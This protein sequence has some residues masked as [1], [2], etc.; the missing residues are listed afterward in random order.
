MYV[1]LHCH[2]TA[3][4]GSLPPAEV[5]RIA[6]GAGV[7][8][9]SLTDHDTVAGNA[10][11]AEE[12]KK[13]GID[14]VTGIEI[15]CE[16][17]SPGTMH[18][19]GYGVDPTSSVLAELSGT[20]IENR[21]NRNPRIIRRLNELNVAVTMEEWEDAAG[22]DVIGRPHLAQILVRKGYANSVKQV[23]DKYLGQGGQAYFDK[24]KLPRKRALE[25]IFASGGIAVLAHPYQLRCTNDAELETIVKDLADLG[26]AG[27]EVMH[28]DHDAAAV[29]K[30]SQLADR[31]GLIRTGGSDFHGTSK[32]SISLGW[33][34]GSRIPR[35]F[36]DD[37]LNAH[38]HHHV[39]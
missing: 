16:F 19:L 18:I 27:I 28:S 4:D 26:L 25:M 39:A 37:L 24:E 1:D 35:A 30:Y 20:L 21:N 22:G 33:C 12:A 29:R 2:S 34:N 7:C 32:K 3:S 23:F 11:A 9:M 31:F 5:V 14:F 17:R 8:A 15:S 6:K 36:F 13:Q 10:E 38:R